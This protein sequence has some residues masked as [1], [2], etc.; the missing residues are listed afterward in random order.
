MKQDTA[1]WTGL[2]AGPFIWLLSF[3]A[4]WSLSGWVCAFHWKPALFAIAGVA[5]IL[6]VACGFLSWSQWQRVGR[7]MPGESGGPVARARILALMGVA[8]NALSVLLIVSQAI[9]DVMLGG[10]E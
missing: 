6:V 5:L 4:R 2:L 7:E 10:C 1:L 8:L 9:P 3:G